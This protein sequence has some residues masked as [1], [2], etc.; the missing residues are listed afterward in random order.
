MS[1]QARNAETKRQIWVTVAV[2]CALILFAVLA[3]IS[4]ATLL[5]EIVLT[6]AGIVLALAYADLGKPRLSLQ[7]KP[8]EGVRIGNA[9]AHEDTVFL[10]LRAFNKP[11]RG[12]PFVSRRTALSCHGEIWCM[13]MN[14][15]PMFNMVIRWSNNPQPVRLDRD[16]GKVIGL[17]D[18]TL[19]RA[20]RF[21][22]IAA[23]ELE[24]LD[25]CRRNME[26]RVANGWN[27]DNYQYPH[28]KHPDRYI[29]GGT[30]R[31]RVKLVHS[32]G[33]DEAEFL[34]HN[35]EDLGQYRLES[36]RAG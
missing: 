9:E 23:D 13:D 18:Q 36:V 27:S 11:R 32:D 20:S 14:N 33:S 5:F 26:E 4:A 28:H 35:P 2:L 8:P 29:P 15:V 7:I 21:I 1:R 30:F 10:K 22:D 34:L 12:W 16:Q 31:V 17:L 3:H 25:I 6:V 24:D 19:M